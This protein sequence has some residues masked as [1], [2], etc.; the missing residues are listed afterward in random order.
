MKNK[1]TLAVVALCLALV[2]F[3]SVKYLLFL[4]DAIVVVLIVGAIGLIGYL[5]DR[6]VDHNDQPGSHSGVSR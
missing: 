1:T 5:M 2:L 6:Q 4:Q 3:M